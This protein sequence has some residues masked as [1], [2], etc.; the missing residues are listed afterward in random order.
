MSPTFAAID[1]TAVRRAVVQALALATGLDNGRIIRA[2][3]QGPVQP[4]PPLPYV[5]FQARRIAIRN[6]FDAVVRSPQDGPT[7]WRYTGERG[8]SFDFITYGRDQDEAYALASSIQCGLDTEPVS[9]ILSQADLSTWTIQDATDVTALLST[10]FEG[11]GLVEAEL[12]LGT[13]VLVDLG[14]IDSVSIVGHAYADGGQLAQLLS[15]TVN[16]I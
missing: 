1:Y 14:Q 2:Q 6:G 7:M 5:S 3:A 10:G 15:Q 8:I 13:D 12:W 16:L 9:D 4:R 11:R